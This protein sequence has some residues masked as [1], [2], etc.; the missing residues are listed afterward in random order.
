[1]EGMWKRVCAADLRKGRMKR[2]R[3]RD[4]RV[5]MVRDR[6]ACLWLGGLDFF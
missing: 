4:S 6:E 5:D 2:R 1:M 3:R